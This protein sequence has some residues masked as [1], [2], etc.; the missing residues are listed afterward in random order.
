MDY[1]PRKRI[2]S[3]LLTPEQQKADVQGRLKTFQDGLKKLVDDTKIQPKPQI[4]PDGPVM[5]LIDLKKYD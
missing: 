1:K 2:M 4:S 5:I 3:I